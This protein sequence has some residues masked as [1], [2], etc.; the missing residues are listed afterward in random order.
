MQDNKTASSSSSSAA[1]KSNAQRKREARARKAAEAALL[2]KSPEVVSGEI[3]EELVNAVLTSSDA[4]GKKPV[5]SLEK[6][7]ADLL[8]RLVVVE[9]QNK[10]LKLKQEKIK[11]LPQEKKDTPVKNPGNSSA[12]AKVALPVVLAPV[13]QVVIAT[14]VTLPPP[15][16]PKPN[17]TFLRAVQNYKPQVN[18]SD[19]YVQESA[20]ALGIVTKARTVETSNVSSHK[21]SAL[22]RDYATVKAFGLLVPSLGEDRTI[23]SVFSSLRDVKLI[24]KLNSELYVTSED[25]VKLVCH[26]PLVTAQDV[27]R[28]VPDSTP[29][30]PIDAHACLLVDVYE[31]ESGSLTPKF[32]AN[33]L[34]ENGSLIW[35]GQ[36][37]VNTAGTA[38]GEGGWYRSNIGGSD[39]IT[40][41]S[42][43][44]ASVYPPHDPCDWI[45]TSTTYKHGHGL[46]LAW[47]TKM[48]IGCVKIVE[49]KL[50]RTINNLIGGPQEF[51]KDFALLDYEV[52]DLNPPASTLGQIYDSTK[53]AILPL[54]WYLRLLPK[55]KVFVHAET[56]YQLRAK[57]FARVRTMQLLR[58]TIHTV[59]TTS[60]TGEVSLLMALFPDR[61]S[62]LI[63][64]TAL[65]AVYSNLR[66]ETGA[67]FSAFT[68]SP[69]VAHNLVLNNQQ[70]AAPSL[71]KAAIVVVGFVSLVG[72]KVLLLIKLA[73]W[74][75]TKRMHPL[76]GASVY[77]VQ[78]MVNIVATPCF[79]ELMKRIPYLGRALPFIEWLFKMVVL[80]C[81]DLAPALKIKSMIL[82]IFP[83][84]MHLVSRELPFY[85]GFTLHMVW[86]MIVC[87][88]WPETQFP[89]ARPEQLSMDFQDFAQLQQEVQENP[90]NRILVV[91]NQTPNFNIPTREVYIAS[92]MGSLM[93]VYSLGRKLL[94]DKFSNY[95]N[96][97]HDHY[98][99]DWMDRPALDRNIVCV[100][101]FDP[102]YA[103]TPT[104]RF[105]HFT[106]KAEC[107]I[108]TAKGK[109]PLPGPVVDS[110]YYW[111]LPTSVPGYVPAKS[112]EHLVDLL[113]SRVLAAPPMDPQLQ[114]AAWENLKLITIP[115]QDVILREDHFDLWWQ[116]IPAKKRARYGAARTLIEETG[117]FNVDQFFAKV[118]IM[119]KLDELLTKTT[120]V[121][122]EI[123]MQL[124]PRSI[125]NVHPCAQL[126]LGPIVYAAMSKLKDIWCVQPDPV[127]RS[128]Y[129]WYYTYGGACTD[130]Q[131]TQWAQFSLIPKKCAVHILMSGDDSLV[132][133]WDHCGNMH[134]F[135]GDFSMFDQSQ[136]FGPLAHQYKFMRALGLTAEYEALF[137]KLARTQY[138]LKT[139]D[140]KAVNRIK[141][142]LRDRPIRHT[143]GA[144][145]SLGN[146]IVTAHAVTEAVEGWINGRNPVDVFRKLGLDVKLKVFRNFDQATFL[147]GMWYRVDSDFGYYWAPLPSRTIKVG[148]SLKNPQ[149]LY[150]GMDFKNASVQ[151]LTDVANGYAAFVQV[152]LLR[153][154]VQHF[155]K[156]VQAEKLPEWRVNADTSVTKPSITSAVWQQLHER[157]GIEEADWLECEAGYP[158]VPFVFHQHPVYVQMNQVD[159]N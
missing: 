149:L 100:T 54:S 15:M 84:M 118:E 96:F 59:Q 110:E 63:Q 3:V 52:V 134:I 93:G 6:T 48:T 82:T 150:P 47:L 26:R 68:N 74:I 156:T 75:K 90:I 76:L 155:S 10:E 80:Y 4:K 20:R 7:V 113:H 109:I 126:V 61:F 137:R 151:F 11:E 103:V 18:P 27:G 117:L 58:S 146:S 34:C 104:Q 51:R 13:E 97:R 16:P 105:A 153:K 101:N 94:C 33:L 29:I 125:A 60:E 133:I 57:S 122:G 25:Q 30:L 159:Y 36:C 78:L 70:P 140:A 35:I 135:E 43:L 141:V 145:T 32:I 128:N 123:K 53:E 56:F 130:E 41:R 23:F 38:F 21:V 17:V 127:L 158:S 37:F 142:D 111:F 73:N 40:Y 83:L 19:L 45:W 89:I 139:R 14:S 5:N 143:G 92:A 44:H 115:Q 65:A 1:P 42:D 81:A 87:T 95:I 72:A 108:L 152:P 66:E 131:L 79:E 85:A 77:A 138:V 71:V 2:P 98:L 124:K 132:V 12:K 39:K 136:S 22:V 129:H 67:L 154:F 62:T 157:Y 120:C 112:D 24:A 86:N 91:R 102:L 147:K 106:A 9:K 28:L 114:L 148:K 99:T 46:T 107:P 144:D 116:H 49:F 64:D 55:K 8:K 88:L 31:T 69:L 121:D 119:A 50:V